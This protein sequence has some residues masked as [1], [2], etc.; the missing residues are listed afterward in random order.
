MPPKSRLRIAPRPVWVQVSR[1]ASARE[2]EAGRQAALQRTP[3]RLHAN[4]PLRHTTSPL[5]IS[6]GSAK[7]FVLADVSVMLLL[8]STTKVL[9]LLSPTAKTASAERNSWAVLTRAIVWLK[10]LPGG[11]RLQVMVEFFTTVLTPPTAGGREVAVRAGQMS[12]GVRRSAWQAAQSGAWAGRAKGWLTWRSKIDKLARGAVDDGYVVWQACSTCHLAQH[13]VAGINIRRGT[14]RHGRH[15]KDGVGDGQGRPW[16]HR[17][18]GPERQVDGRSR[19]RFQQ[20][21]VCPVGDVE[22]LQRERCVV[23]HHQ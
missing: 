21:R 4:S 20:V 16:L 15:I 19:V 9:A 2:S 1:Q 12:S 5:P 17:D 22:A 7:L 13:G 6:S 23:V 8:S 10:P 11:G 14:Q 18:C 3:A